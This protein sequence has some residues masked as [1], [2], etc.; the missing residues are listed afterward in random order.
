MI[1]PSQELPMP[2]PF[3]RI[4]T[5]RAVAALAALLASVALPPPAAAQVLA[6]STVDNSALDAQLMYQLLIGEM[7]LRAGEPGTAYEVLL[8]AARRTKDEQLFRR[9]TDI[10]L[11]ARAGDQALAAV[12][13][14]RA[15]LPASLE[16]LRFHVQLLVALNRVPEALEPLRALIAQTPA[17]ARAAT[18]N[19]LPRFFARTADPKQAASLLEQAL[20]PYV[21][22]ADTSAAARVALG[23]AWL[24][25]QDPAK[26]LDLA[27]RAHRREPAA[28]GPA[29]LAADLLPGSPA[30]EV[31]VLAHLKA[32]PDSHG[33][34]LTYVRVLTTSQ[35]YAEAIEQ[36]DSV[37]RIAPT[38]APP[39]LTLGAL[40]IELRHPAEATAAVQKF[41]QLTQDGAVTN[42]IAAEAPADGPDDADEA[43]TAATSEALTQAWLLLAQAAE[44]QG[45]YKAAEAWLAKVD[46]PQRLLEV[47]SRRASVLA[48]QGKVK[49]ARE[50][51]RG[52]PE[53]TAEDARA[54]MLAE[55]QLLRDVKQW[56]DAGAVLA[57]ANQK[58]PDDVDLLYEESM[59]AEKLNRLDD[60]E[61][62][63][64]RVIALKPDHHHA[65][66]ALG[67]SLAERN[68]RLAEAKT[69][70]QKA[71]ALSPGEPFITDSLGW[72]EYRL[73]NR[74][75]ALRLLRGAY[76]S[77]PDTE[78]AAHLGEV[79]WVAGQRDEARRVLREARSRDAANDVLREMLTRLRVDL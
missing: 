77:R 41:V 4:G 36:L 8:D 17:P 42:P 69:L 2:A 60:M 6:L 49:E 1:F 61:R 48:R 53:R 30:A 13:A 71:L 43:P 46:S 34:R 22:G 18:I 19:S 55:A 10:A 38:L 16:A 50:L 79:L 7:E 23:R 66:N 70:I 65:Y 54:K 78:I 15:A 63:L 51:V 27:Q 56:S 64:R 57:A 44:Q 58:F 75:E 32:K 39:W 25:A 33:V 47:Q 11:E 28:E 21:D 76:Q 31:I 40:Q 20:Q 62:L 45:D 26:A 73:G 74:D 3:L 12:K 24:S 67:Y 29:L 52:V 9:A 68:L 72:V 37:T 59:A 35:R 14:W 5:A